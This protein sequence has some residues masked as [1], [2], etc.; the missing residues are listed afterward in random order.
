[1]PLFIASACGDKI[2]PGN[3][4]QT[5]PVIK[6][7]V[8]ET[9]AVTE[10]PFLYEAMGTVQAGSTIHLSGKLMG[11]V[12]QIEVREGDRVKAG[13]V[14]VRIDDRQVQSGLRQAEAG[15][16]EAR[17][18][19]SAAESARVGA[20]AAEKLSE[21]TYRRYLNMKKDETVSAQEFDEAESRYLQAKANA[22]R[23]DA[24]VESAT[25]LVRKAEAALA[26]AAVT[27]KDAV[28]LAPEEGIVTAKRV[29][30]GDLAS[31]GQILLALDTLQGYRVDI[32]VPETYISKV[33]QGHVVKVT[34]PSI[35]SGPLESTVST[36]VPSAD[37]R[38]RSFL[39][40]VALPGDL[41]LRSGMFARAE[42]P[43]GQTPRILVPSEAI[44]FQGQLTGLYMVDSQGV[45]R[46]RLI[47]LGRT[48]EGKVEVLSGLKKGDRFV[49]RIE[50]ALS[51]GARVEVKP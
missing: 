45:A 17:K 41:P 13:Q 46:F 8:V 43:L 18:G 28:V 49:A 39:V 15:L 6:G 51:D 32:M 21:A 35:T 30:E 37:Q 1:M 16:S 27:R 2:E 19:L 36:V 5:P 34:I 23:T 33:K 31:P 3:T 20:K 11:V 44:V 24:M 38:T 14:L 40:K 26:S 25:A 48:F 47:R 9:A 10:Q 4:L 22:T 29:E 50:P 42:I 7:I 12:E